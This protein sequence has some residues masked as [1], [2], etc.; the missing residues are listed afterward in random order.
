M[1]FIDTE[2]GSMIDRLVSSEALTFGTWEKI[3]DK[4]QKM[5]I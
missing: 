5:R 1:G 3:V 4:L 2:R